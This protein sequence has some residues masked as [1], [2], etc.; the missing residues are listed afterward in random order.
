M[1]TRLRACWELPLGLVLELPLTLE[2][3]CMFLS[4]FVALLFAKAFGGWSETLFLPTSWNSTRLFTRSHLDLPLRMPPH[5]LSR[6]SSNSGL[7]A[8]GSRIRVQGTIQMSQL[9]QLGQS[10]G[11]PTYIT[12][13]TS[14]LRPGELR[15]GL[16]ML[17]SNDDASACALKILA[18]CWH[19]R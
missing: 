1:A 10:P 16:R 2:A 12:T 9:G 6:E 18:R 14:F 4:E 17:R 11:S 13:S 3:A 8:P 7:Q 5:I 15:T 19:R